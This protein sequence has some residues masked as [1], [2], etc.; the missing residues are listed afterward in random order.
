MMK[1][2]SAFYLY[3]ALPHGVKCVRDALCRLFVQAAHD[4]D[5]AEG[6]DEARDDLVE[7]EESEL[8]PYEDGDAARDD[9][10]ED[11]VSRGAPPEEGGEQRGAEG[12]AE[13]CPCIGDHVEDEALGI[14][15]ER[16][17]KRGDRED[18]EAA[19][20]DEFFLACSLVQQRAV[21]ILR[22]GGS[23]N[24]ELRRRRAH[25]GGEDGG[26][27]EARDE[28]VEDR[29]RH[30]E[31]DGFCRRAEE[32]IGEID[33]TDHADEDG[34]GERDGDPRHGDV[35]GASQLGR[36][37]DRHEAH[38]DV[39]LPEVAE[40]PTHERDELDEA[41]R[42]VVGFLE[43]GEERRFHRMEGR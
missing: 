2:K 36:G 38:E 43:G 18:G 37:A 29:V 39:R 20:P 6:E 7:T 9:A 25:D 28:R 10:C 33:V 40:S 19:D 14:H 12:G 22:E 17:G 4:V 27:D 31:E 5:G 34:G 1:D 24:E 21:E 35:H 16:Q 13:A 41:E 23:R 32:R 26:E 15:G 8:L 42:R 3:L 30:H 11:A